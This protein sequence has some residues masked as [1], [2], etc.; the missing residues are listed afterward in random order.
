MPG[1]SGV[2]EA[3]SDGLDWPT[4]ARED[5]FRLDPGLGPGPGP[6]PN[7]S[8]G[9]APAPRS[10]TELP[11][12]LWSALSPCG[13]DKRRESLCPRPLPAIPHG[14]RRAEWLPYPACVASVSLWRGMASLH[15]AWSKL[16]EEKLPLCVA[17]DWDQMVFQG[18]FQPKPL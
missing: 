8:P 12:R 5:S 4:A 9:P 6:G 18:P 14:L 3:S 17:G 1:C 7:P 15:G 11:R 10:G 2:S 13:E 16:A